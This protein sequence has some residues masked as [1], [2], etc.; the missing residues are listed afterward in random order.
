[1]KRILCFL[2]AVVLLLSLCACGLSDNNSAFFYY[3]RIKFQYGSDT[4]DGVIVSEKRDITGH[5]DDLSYLI[6]LYL[7]GPMDD[8]LVSP[9]PADT[10]L[11]STRTSAGDIELR[12]SEMGA[13]FPDSRYSLACACLALTCLELTDATYVTVIS[14]ERSLRLSREDLTLLDTDTENPA[15]IETTM[16]V[17]Q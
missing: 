5:R 9:F 6:S 1:M 12:L 15:T 17:P 8:A 3:R 11:L 10:R 13:D 16:E 14:G 2:L 7:L 4:G